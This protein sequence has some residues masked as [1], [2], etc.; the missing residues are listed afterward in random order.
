MRREDSGD[1][2]GLRSLRSLRTL[3]T[4]PA[5]SST[6]CLRQAPPAIRVGGWT[7][8]RNHHYP[9]ESDYKNFVNIVLYKRRSRP[10]WIGFFSQS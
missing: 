10:Y 2:G 6:T 8:L 5:W 7:R 9:P 4:F 3:P 1:C